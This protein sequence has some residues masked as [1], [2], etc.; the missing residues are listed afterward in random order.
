MANYSFEFKLHVVE[1]YL[2]SEISYQDLAISQGINNYAMIVINENWYFK[3]DI[4]PF[5]S[6]CSR[7][8]L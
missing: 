4:I 1:L 3:K 2:S 6:L 8:I 7:I 5:F